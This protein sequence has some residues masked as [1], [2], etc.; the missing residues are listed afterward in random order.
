MQDGQ[1]GGAELGPDQRE[2]E[3]VGGGVR[4]N[5]LETLKLNSNFKITRTMWESAL[6]GYAKLPRVRR[7][8]YLGALIV[9]ERGQHESFFLCVRWSTLI[10]FG[11]EGRVG[12]GGGKGGN[13]SSVFQRRAPLPPLHN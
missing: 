1:K 6:I 11:S 4:H 12:W 9:R 8:L 10:N 13:F 2:E 5:Q 7:I 3:E